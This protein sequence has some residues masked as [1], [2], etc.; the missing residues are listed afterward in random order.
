MTLRDDSADTSRTRDVRPP[1]LVMQVSI[2][3]ELGRTRLVYVLD[4]PTGAAKFSHFT[5]TSLD[6]KGSPEEFHRYLL[7]KFEQLGDLLDIDGSLL[8]KDGVGHKLVN[9]G[10]WL[11]DELIPFELRASYRKFRQ[12]VHSWW[13]ISD[14]P[15]I[16]WELMKPYDDNDPK[17]VL[18]D[19]FLA[20]R[21]QM[22]RWLTGNS[23]PAREISVR[24]LAALR[25]A[26]LPQEEEEMRLLE[27]LA[28]IIDRA[29]EAP[30]LES[31]DDVLNYLKTCSVQLLHFMG[32]GIHNAS[33][34]DES[35]IPLPDGSH[36]R[37]GE[38][39]GP[40][41]TRIRSNQPFVFM[42]ICSAAQQGWALT[43]LSGWTSRWI[44]RCGC[45]ALVAPLWP[46][47]DQI[48]MSF[49]ETF[50]KALAS[51]DPLGE[52][53]Q[54]ARRHIFRERPGDPS[55]LAYAVYGHPHARVTF[56]QD[57]SVEEIPPDTGIHQRDPIIWPNR[58]RRWRWRTWWNWA[59]AALIFAGILQ[60]SADSILGVLFDPGP[61]LERPADVS[62]PS[63]TPTPPPPPPPVEEVQDLRLVITGGSAQV[64]SVLKTAVRK[65]TK[66]LPA[67]KVSGWTV[68]L[69]LDPPAI[70]RYEDFGTSM[71]SCRLTGEA[72]AKGL[73]GSIDL[74]SV[75]KPNSQTDEYSACSAAAKSLA[76]D[77]VSELIQ[78]LGTKGET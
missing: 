46:V 20:L 10:R 64:N 69:R 57:S 22:T 32:H 66:D 40:L 15:W 58:R 29:G 37:P 78:Q 8:L 52:A 23:T 67:E 71:V 16:P 38:L 76:K 26:E 30:R 45:G 41:A 55:V 70:A 11:W 27:D 24:S 50:Y 59:A 1:D 19:D 6:F 14:E 28:K 43:R 17:D 74:G 4:S 77:I 56:G 42:N 39:E 44:G 60:I 72:S 35:G 31:A 61:I 73:G 33:Q 21:F 75:S 47:R 62:E 7:N 49:A 13:V 68:K 34:A 63:P 3:S 5:T 9:F 18:D 65:A 25:T 36:F 48:A 51:G 12:H 53:A 54:K 2:Q